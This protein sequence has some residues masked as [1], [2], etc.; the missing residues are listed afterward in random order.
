MQGVFCKRLIKIGDQFINKKSRELGIVDYIGNTFV[1]IDIRGRKYHH[2]ITDFHKKWEPENQDTSPDPIDNDEIV[3]KYG[4][5]TREQVIQEI[6][7]VHEKDV[8][9]P[10]PDNNPKNMDITICE[11]KY[12]YRGV[13]YIIS[14]SVNVIQT[15]TGFDI[16]PHEKGY[17]YIDSDIHDLTIEDYI[18]NVFNNTA[19]F[20]S[21]IP[22]NKENY[23]DVISQ[24]ESGINQFMDEAIPFIESDIQKLLEEKEKIQNLIN[25][26]QKQD[27]SKK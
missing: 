8:T 7:R 23:N 18:M 13:K 22:L 17:V 4:N 19:P 2:Y 20:Y 5:M 3:S 21:H 16:E 10:S 14:L 6:I 15:K 12:E 27:T 11:N 24:M 1:T 25:F 9:K 26:Y